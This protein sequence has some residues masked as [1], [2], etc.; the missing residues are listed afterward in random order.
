M[1]G[2]LDDLAVRPARQDDLS[3]M[4]RVLERAFA[5]D[6]PFGEFIFRRESSRRTRTGRMMTALIRHRFLPCGGAEV[7][8]SGGDVVGALL[9]YP[10]GYRPGGWREI[11][12]GPE[13]GWAMGP[14]VPGGMAVDAANRRVSPGVPHLFGIYLGCEPD[15]QRAGIGRALFGSFTAKA[16]AAQVPA[17]WLC[18]DSNLGYY[19]S[20][21]SMRIGGIRL[22][23]RGPEVNVMTWFPS[24]V[25]DGVAR[26]V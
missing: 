21:G 9:W 20:G 13:F 7:A 15:L 25:T 17:Y 11:L 23:R 4:S 6:D 26:Q 14:G 16:E 12:A 19:R 2:R 22:G 3:S 18:K 10:V 5:V 8:T 1:T 24:G